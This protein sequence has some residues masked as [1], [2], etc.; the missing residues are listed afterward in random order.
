MSQKINHIPTRLFANWSLTPA[1]F[2]IP[3]MILAALMNGYLFIKNPNM[4]GDA[5]YYHSAV[6]NFFA[7]KGWVN[8]HGVW[9][10]HEPGYGMLSYFIYLL[11]G[12]I[13]YSGMLVS[14]IAYLLFVPTVYFAVDY[15]FGKQSAML[16]AFWATFWP[17]I[18]SYSYVNLTDC[19]YIFVLFLGFSL[20]T[21]VLL[22][23]QDYLKS[24][25]LG[26][27]LGLAYLIREP[28]SLFVA[29]L[30]IASLYGIAIQNWIIAHR[31]KKQSFYQIRSMLIVP[32]AATLGFLTVFCLY[33]AFIYVQSGVWSFSTKVDPVI[34]MAQEVVSDLSGEE[35]SN[36]ANSQEPVPDAEIQTVQV[37]EKSES[38]FWGGIT[39]YRPEILNLFR[40]VY[41]L[42]IGL[43]RMTWHALVVLGIL[44]V[45][46]PFL[47]TR[48][49]LASL[50]IDAH[51]QRIMLAFIIF[52]SPA[53]L[54]MLVS[55]L[56][57][58]LLMQYAIYLIIVAAFLSTRLLE[59]MLESW[60]RRYSDQWTFLLCLVTLGLLL[61]IGSPNLFH[62]ITKP[63]AHLNIRAAGIWLSENTQNADDAVIIAPKKAEVVS[64]YAKGKMFPE[65]TSMNLAS[66]TL[67]EIGEIVNSEEITYLVLEPYYLSNVLPLE[68][69]W[70]DPLLAEE[71][72][73][74]L[75]YQ[76]SSDRF[77]I[78]TTETS[79]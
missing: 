16:A 30:A 17:T 6:H 65:E 40:S 46:Y 15:L 52:F 5:L 36:F 3:L 33:I 78:Y 76:D 2:L 56:F 47:S 50:R 32:S 60:G 35:I 4:G 66:Y 77:Q 51:R 74:L 25:M 45:I 55:R 64:F 68:F 37:D 1:Q 20:Y 14:A 38:Q 44:L 54:H 22:D 42:V 58:R 59:R 10:K 75:L 70:N 13:E 29:T 12:D 49:I 11:V 57:E 43:S 62:A 27:I 21:R 18:L 9:D 7:G 8:F 69:L 34:P 67:P 73:L 31:R 41:P 39:W 53:V 24:I 63:H 23:K 28:E 19:V 61:T 48:R 72:G 71:L 79:P 26:I